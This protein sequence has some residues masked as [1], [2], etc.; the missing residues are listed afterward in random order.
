MTCERE[1]IEAEWKGWRDHDEVES[2]QREVEEKKTR[3]RQCLGSSVN[4]LERTP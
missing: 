1:E 4:H 2:R 3:K